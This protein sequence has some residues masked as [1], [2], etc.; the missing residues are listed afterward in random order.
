MSH[1]SSHAHDSQLTPP[2]MLRSMRTPGWVFVLLILLI[3]GVG[4]YAYFTTP[5][6]FGLSS[7]VRTP[8]G[9]NAAPTS[10]VPQGAR[11]S[12]GQT[13]VLGSTNGVVQ[14]MQR[15]KDLQ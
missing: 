10:A 8:G 1:E 7:V 6:P 9:A 4:I 12:A 11:T 15:N 14:A 2:T 5:L 3:I 13:L